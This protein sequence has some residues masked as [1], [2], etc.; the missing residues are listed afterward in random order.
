LDSQTVTSRVQQW[1]DPVSCKHSRQA[2]AQSTAVEVPDKVTQSIGS[3]AYIHV[4]PYSIGVRT[5]L[6]WLQEEHLRSN[7]CCT[8]TIT[9]LMNST[10]RRR[11][12]LHSL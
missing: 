4:K 12:R 5:H 7:D 9:I 6:L 8:E 10:R 11:P 1:F 2:H 3:P